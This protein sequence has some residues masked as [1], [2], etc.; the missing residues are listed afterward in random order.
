MVGYNSETYTVG[1]LQQRNDMIYVCTAIEVEHVTKEPSK[2]IVSWEP[3]G[4]NLLKKKLEPH[5]KTGHELITELCFM[6]NLPSSAETRIT[7]L[8]NELAGRQ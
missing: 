3:L 5:G 4:L 6:C 1:Q 2:A 7:M 8:I